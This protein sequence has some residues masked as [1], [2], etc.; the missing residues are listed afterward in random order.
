M[1]KS[2]AAVTCTFKIILKT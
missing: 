1:R 2:H